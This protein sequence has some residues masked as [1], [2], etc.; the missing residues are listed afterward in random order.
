M[1]E[2]RKRD[3]GAQK[4]RRQNGESDSARLPAVTNADIAHEPV[5]NRAV[6][7]DRRCGRAG[8][9]D[10]EVYAPFV[11]RKRHRHDQRLHQSRGERKTPRRSRGDARIA[12]EALRHRQSLADLRDINQSP[13]EFRHLYFVPQSPSR[14]HRGHRFQRLMQTR[15]AGF[16]LIET[17]VSAAIAS[18]ILWALVAMADRYVTAAA[19]LDTRL[20]AQA[21]VE[22]VLE[23]LSSEAASAWAV[24]VPATDV[25]GVS[26]ADGHELDLFTEDVAHRPYGW[27]YTYDAA[28][29][30]ITRYAYAPGAAPVAGASVS[31]VDVFSA[32]PLALSTLVSST[33]PQADPLF[34]GTTV[35]DVSYAYPAMP[36]AIGGTGV[37]EVHI[38]AA[39]VDRL[40]R[41]ASATAPTM[42]TVVV[43][44]T[45]SPA[46][47][48]T[49]TPAPPPIGTPDP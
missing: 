48:V 36:S 31:G 49:P 4:Q 25:L 33:S 23:R 22:R 15:Q 38:V 41:F 21:G 16:T 47:P 8:E 37:V 20:S 40:E 6:I 45:P 26:N 12:F 19:Q 42:F 3:C 7:H 43:E 30:T 28:S 44:Y 46:P 24:D 10:G 34:A 18:T 13:F 32:R 27:A 17:L 29:Q 1:S 39:G 14:R 5:R 9:P 2:Q 11:R 35:R